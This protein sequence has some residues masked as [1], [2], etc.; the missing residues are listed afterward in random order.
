ML[1]TASDHLGDRGADHVDTEDLTVFVVSDNLDKSFTGVLDL[2]LSDG[3]EGKFADLYLETLVSGFCFGQSDA[4]NL[5][6]A[7]R[8][9][10]Y[11]PVIDRLWTLT[12]NLL[13]SHNSFLKSDV[14]ELG[15]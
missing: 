2:C 3:G 13:D 8:A 9:V 7:V 15:C 14:R 5:W 10:R 11:L 12:R 6:V 1:R 4:G